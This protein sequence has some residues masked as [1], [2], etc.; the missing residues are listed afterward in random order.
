MSSDNANFGVIKKML[1]DESAGWMEA[2]SSDIEGANLRFDFSLHRLKNDP[3]GYDRDVYLYFQD[4]YNDFIETCIVSTYRWLVANDPV[5]AKVISVQQ[6]SPKIWE[7]VWKQSLP[8]V[9]LTNYLNVSNEDSLDFLG[10]FVFEQAIPSKVFDQILDEERGVAS[11]QRWWGLGQWLGEKFENRLITR[12]GPRKARAI[13]RRYTQQM[14]IRMFQE[15]ASR[16]DLSKLS[17]NPEDLLHSDPG[18]NAS[19]FFRASFDAASC[20]GE[21]HQSKNLHLIGQNLATARQLSD[22]IC[23]LDE[24]VVTGVI[25][26]PVVAAAS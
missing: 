1:N 11:L 22:E 23:D 18:L 9:I 4:K 21:S 2:Y 17:K 24:D 14:C 20:I 12:T 3:V 5:F 26:L 16:Y 7:S 10:S 13:L 25:S 6:Y 15:E 8:F 19:V